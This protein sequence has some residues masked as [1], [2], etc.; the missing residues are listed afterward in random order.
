MKVNALFF[1]LNYTREPCFSNALWSIH[2]EKLY[3]IPCSFHLTL[4]NFGKGFLP[5][6]FALKMQKKKKINAN[7]K[8]K[9]W[10]S[11][12]FMLF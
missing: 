2:K 12:Y 7:N 8:A 1:G 11:E 3:K 4:T 5:D 10:F 9:T 6:I